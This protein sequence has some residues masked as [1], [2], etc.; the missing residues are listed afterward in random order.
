MKVMHFHFGKDGGA[1]RFFVHLVNGLARRG[2][3]QT[4]VIR[5]GRGWRSQ[6]ENAATIIESN[7][8]NLSPDRLLLPMKVSSIARRQKP[9]ALM[10]WATRASRLMPAYG[11]CIKLSRLGDYPTNLGYFKNTDVLVCNQPDIGA[12]VRRLGWKRGVEVIS[13]FTNTEK[14]A[15][16]ARQEVS[17]PDGVPIVFSMGRFVARKGFAMLIEAVS[18]LP[19][20]HLWLAGD[21]EERQNL[22]AVAAKFGMTGRVH[23][24]G[25]QADVRRFLAAADLFV[26]PSSHEPLGNVILEAWAQQKPVISSRAEGPRWF[27]HEAQ[28]GLLFDI[29]DTE[30]LAVCLKTLVADR[31]LA[32]KIAAGGHETLMRQFSEQ[33]VVDSYLDLFTRKPADYRS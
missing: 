9:D 33:A 10:S 20:A 26:M 28:N 18:R 6:I 27:M 22:E 14:V 29:N 15:P 7:F 16:V 3:E 21:G 2:V 31:V 11:G 32:E 25:W 4:V 8:R 24:L 19:D 13:N 17:T 30:G 12:H 1:E 5:P 23:F